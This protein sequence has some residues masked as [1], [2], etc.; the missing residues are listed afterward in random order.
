MSLRVIDSGNPTLDAND[1]RRRGLYPDPNDYEPI[2]EA[3]PRPALVTK[4]ATIVAPE[5]WPERG[6]VHELVKVVQ[7]FSDAPAVFALYAGLNVAGAACGR[8]LSIPFG[9]TMMYTNQWT[10]LVADSTLSRKSVTLGESK[11]ALERLMP[12]RMGARCSP[13][14]LIDELEEGPVRL[15]VFDE[16]TGLLGGMTRDHMAGLREDYTSL[17]GGDTMRARTRTLGRKEL[18]GVHLSMLAA[19]NASWL[20]QYLKKK[21]LRGGF[22]A[23]WLLVRAQSDRYNPFPEAIPRA[24]RD[25]LERE[26]ARLLDQAKTPRE[27]RWSAGAR[28]LYSDGRERMEHRGGARCSAEM[29]AVRGRLADAAL[30]LA[31]TLHFDELGGQGDELSELAVQR[32]LALAEFSIRSWESFLSNDLTEG[33]HAENCKRVLDLLR[34]SEGGTA[35][36]RDILRGTHLKVKGLQ[37]IE[38]TLT[39]SGQVRVFGAAKQSRV[40]RLVDE[41]PR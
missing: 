37:E 40:W 8:A 34:A 21:D 33:E 20:G 17:F 1:L 41:V 4:P 5:A 7:E 11:R 19:S 3:C 39:G 26:M 28:A 27:L 2:V 13:E 12:E 18:S 24:R 32:G 15:F 23:R 14:G 25:L 30:K 38:D 36:Q 10:V 31:V 9:T 29:G 6:Y 22:A 35:T 16:L